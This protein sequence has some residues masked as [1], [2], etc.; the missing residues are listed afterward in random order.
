MKQKLER[1]KGTT[2]GNFDTAKRGFTKQIKI[3][4]AIDEKRLTKFK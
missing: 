3:L 4:E 1:N 2:L